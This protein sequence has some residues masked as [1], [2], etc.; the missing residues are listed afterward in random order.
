LVTQ[1]ERAE[2]AR[3]H[4]LPVNADAARAEL[5]A[6]EHQ[7]I[8]LRADRGAHVI[9]GIFQLIEIFFDNSSEWM[10]RADEALFCLAPLKQGEAGEPHELP[11]VLGNEF[12]L[13]GKMQAQ[14]PGD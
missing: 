2:H 14:L 1:A 3:L 13:L 6:I 4:I 10:L 11:A 7:I 12:E 5:D 8:A 9:R